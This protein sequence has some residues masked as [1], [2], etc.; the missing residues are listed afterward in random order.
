MDLPR[1]EIFGGDDIETF[2]HKLARPDYLGAS[3]VSNPKPERPARPTAT[4]A[5]PGLDKLSGLAAR[6]DRLVDEMI[7][8][9]RELV[10]L[11]RPSDSLQGK[12]LGLFA[13]PLTD[14]VGELLTPHFWIAPGIRIGFEPTA[15]VR[16]TV[17]PK[18]D[19]TVS[20]ESC[21]NLVRLAYSGLSR[22]FSLDVALAWPELENAERY[23]L[24]ISV[25]SSR[26]AACRA[27]LRFWQ[28]DNQYI[29]MPLAEFGLDPAERNYN[30]SGGLTLPDLLALDHNSEPLFLLLFD[31]DAALELDLA[32]LNLYFA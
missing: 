1:L 5:S 18:H 15:R 14:P 12:L 11:R 24:G 16:L 10:M 4:A 7:S 30:F 17:F 32:Y 29:E 22:W 27:V 25:K 26:K 19:H 13:K 31:T 8:I 23:Q 3:V 9:K 20:P 2:A 28:K 6:L 21:L